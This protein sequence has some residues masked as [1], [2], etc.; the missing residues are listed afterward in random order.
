MAVAPA[1]AG[2][3]DNNDRGAE[4]SRE[5]NL[6]ILAISDFHG[7]IATSSGSFGGTGR[8]DYLSANVAARDADADNSIFVSAGDLIGRTR[9]VTTRA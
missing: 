4:N 9:S 3:G 5:V 7:N 2:K 8:A 1:T 6:Q